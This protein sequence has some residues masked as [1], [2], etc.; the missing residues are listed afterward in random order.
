MP[1]VFDTPDILNLH[2][3]LGFLYLYEDAKPPP[4][5]EGRIICVVAHLALARPK[6]GTRHFGYAFF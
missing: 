6:F 5:A 2:F 4:I 1:G 3:E